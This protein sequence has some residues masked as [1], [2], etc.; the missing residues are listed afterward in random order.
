MMCASWQH[1]SWFSTTI[2][3][4]LFRAPEGSAQEWGNGFP[5]F[6][7]TIEMTRRK[8]RFTWQRCFSF[9]VN[10]DLTLKFPKIEPFRYVS[11]FC[12]ALSISG[13]LIL[14]FLLRPGLAI[15]AQ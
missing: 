8:S 2:T 3:V 14:V 12:S 4:T 15:R 7:T 5:W 9:L 1:T 6:S 10:Y 11:I 13:I